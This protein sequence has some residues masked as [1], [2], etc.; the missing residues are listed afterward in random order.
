MA[1]EYSDFTSHSIDCQCFFWL[2]SEANLPVTY[3]FYQ[4]VL[5]LCTGD[6]QLIELVVEEM[7][8]WASTPAGV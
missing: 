6:I 5:I 4:L 8:S 3:I 1:S 2:V 7:T